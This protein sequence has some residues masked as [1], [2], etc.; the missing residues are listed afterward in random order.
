M[1]MR[2]SVPAEARRGGISPSLA[3]LD[4]PHAALDVGL[5]ERRIKRMQ[6]YC[7]AHELAL[8][9]HVKTHKLVPI[10]RLQ[11]AAGAVGV[12]CQKLGEAEAMVAAGIDDVLVSFPL[13]GKH[14]LRRLVALAARARISTVV[15]SEVGA[16][17]LSG[18]AVAAELDLPLL[19]ECDTGYAR[20]GVQTPTA[21]AELAALVERLPG[22]SFKG[23]LT[24]PTSARTGEFFAAARAELRRRGLDPAVM[25]AGGTAGAFRAHEIP[26]VNELR[27]GTYVYGDRACVAN[28]SVP[29]AECALTVLSTVVSRPARGRAILDAGSK[30]L[31]SDAA[32]GLEDGDY[33]MVLDLPGSRLRRLSEEHGHLDVSRSDREPD[34]GEVLRVLPNHACGTANMHD[35]VAVHRDGRVE[36][37]WKLDARGAV[38]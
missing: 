13:I 28:G 31:S 36:A 37:I 1:T 15:D 4:T 17:G 27:V 26:E 20:T 5:L 7:D 19:V 3:N 18:S 14:K 16:R 30:A 12:A 35:D 8:R 22:V 10:A 9:P 38:R 24:Y 21:A 2:A 29:L 23:L 33:G 34:I 32:Q 11:L 25:S 6:L